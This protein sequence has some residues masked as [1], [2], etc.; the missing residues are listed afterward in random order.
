M[1]LAPLL[2]AKSLMWTSR[3]VP[4]AAKAA[5][6]ALPLRLDVRGGLAPLHAL[7]LDRAVA[8]GQGGEPPCRPPRRLY[9]VHGTHA[10]G[11]VSRAFF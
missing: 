2:P 6:A 4:A 5:T 7:L 3:A 9:V 11:S 1:Y 10:G 8:T